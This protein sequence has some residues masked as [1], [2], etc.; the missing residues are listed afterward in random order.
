GDLG[1]LQVDDRQVLAG[2]DLDRPAVGGRHHDLA[3]LPLGHGHRLAFGTDSSAAARG[4]STPGPAGAHASGCVVMK[5]ADRPGSTWGARTSTPAASSWSRKT[6]LLSCSA[7]PRLRAS[8]AI[9]SARLVIGIGTRYSRASS[10]ASPMSFRA[11]ARL[12]VG[13]Y[14]PRK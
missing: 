6:T 1:A 8:M 12:K 11:R 7:Q 10:V 3:E 4:T 9:C 5:R 13:G 14:S 2:A